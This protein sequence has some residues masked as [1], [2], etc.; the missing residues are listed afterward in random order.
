MKI[1]VPD[2][3]VILKWV[4]QKESEADFAAAYQ[5]LEDLTEEKAEI[6]LPELWKYEVCNILSSKQPQ[7]AQELIDILMDYSFS[8]HYLD[9]DDCKEIIAI[10]KTIGSCTFYDVSY[11][12]LA[13]KLGG[14]M[15]TADKKYHE[16]AS[17]LKYIKLLKSKS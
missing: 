3:S 13:I 2:A 8:E 5:I 9:R 1:I 17:G 15:V 7:Y 12:Y 11:H 6:H 4:L 14:T 16:K 10:Q